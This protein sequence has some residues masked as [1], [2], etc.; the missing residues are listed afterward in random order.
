MMSNNN[1]ISLTKPED[2]AYLKNGETRH[3][4]AGLA[5]SLLNDKTD[6]IK[7]ENA[8]KKIGMAKDKRMDVFA[9]VAA[10]LHI[11]NIELTDDGSSTGVSDAGKV[12]A[13][14]AA[15]ILGLDTGALI[16]AITTRQIKIPGQAAL[17][18]K[19]LTKIQ[20]VHARD[21][22]GK[23]LYSRLFDFIC[24]TINKSIDAGGENYIGI[25][26]IAGF[27]YFEENSF[28]QF[29]INY[30]NE[31]LQQFFNAR[32]LKDEMELYRREGLS[33]KTVDY[34]DNQ[35]MIELIESP[36]TGI[37][38]VLDEEMKLPKPL[39]SHFAESLHQN[40]SKNFRFQAPRTS[41]IQKYRGMR[42]E[43]AFILR[44]FAGAVCYR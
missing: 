37:L 16:E 5:D 15:N 12:A 25:L 40:H 21:A 28:E 14:K 23:A 39:D 19:A 6:F 31:K 18:K 38:D 32:T 35:D 11:G 33:V 22:L 8:M 3:F 10:V 27:E 36:K 42:N 17:V 44:H 2:Y 43:E 4:G 24:L 7:T 13:G 1:W 41:K 30:C 20:A 9:V 29:C 34:V 26:D